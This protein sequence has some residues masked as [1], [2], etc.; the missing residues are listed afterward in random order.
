VVVVSGLALGIDAAAQAATIRAG[1]RTWTFLGSGLNDAS[2]YPPSN[3]GLAKRILETGGALLSEFPPGMAGFKHIFALRNRLIA[4]VS[5]GTVVVEAAER[6]GSLITASAALAANRE[7]FAVPGD[8]RSEMSAGPHSLIRRGAAL[9]TSA[10]NVLDALGL[11]RTRPRSDA[12]LSPEEKRLL[13]LLQRE[14]A[15]LDELSRGAT[16]PASE[17]ARLLS[18]LEISGRVRSIGGGLWARN[19]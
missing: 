13:G 16:I 10:E 2:V 3:R 1:G 19:R 11:A 6:S 4:G 7:V 9:V 15:S 5:L 8:A 17:T 12:S 18:L 14:P